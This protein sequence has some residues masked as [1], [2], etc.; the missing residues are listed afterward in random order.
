MI[1]LAL[2]AAAAA[3]ETGYHAEMARLRAA[4]GRRARR[5]T[6]AVLLTPQ[7]WTEAAHQQI[8]L[9]ATRDA[10]R[11]RAR[12]LAQQMTASEQAARID[13][14]AI[15]GAPDAPMATIGNPAA[16][17]RLPAPGRVLVG[18]G[19]VD[20]RGIRSR[21]IRLAP[22]ADAPLIAP[23]AG[24][25]AYAGPYRGYGDVLILEHGRGWTSLVAG[26]RLAAFEIG[27]WIPQGR[28][29]GTA[30]GPL[31]IELRHN[32]TP[33]DI[34]ATANRLAKSGVQG[35]A[36]SQQALSR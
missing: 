4:E 19:T 23:G 6:L 34:L 15:E 9:D 35:S 22:A 24:R 3:T 26:G 11:R 32:G 1:A 27:A 2:L 13:D 29:I 18:F 8:L 36:I 10:L 28:A 5:P 25:V 30:R 21:G 31:L 7:G 17:Y 33:V 14:L 16:A 12:R 20:K